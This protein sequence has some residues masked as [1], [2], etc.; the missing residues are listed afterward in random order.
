MR[1]H[2]RFQKTRSYNEFPIEISKRCPPNI[3]I[4]NL[5]YFSTM[6]PSWVD[7]VLPQLKIPLNFGEPFFSVRKFS[8][9]KINNIVYYLQF[10]V[11]LRPE[12]P[13][14]KR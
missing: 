9:Q 6:E 8:K 13:L 11:R 10:Y 7:D 14:D 4:S 1:S 12:N 2:L 3:E 5:L